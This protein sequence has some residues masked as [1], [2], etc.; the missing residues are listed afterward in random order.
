MRHYLFNVVSD[1]PAPAAGNDM[2]SW[3]L[4]YK[5]NVD[6]EVFVPVHDPTRRHFL[7]AQPGDLLWFSLDR[8]LIG[9]V[10][11]LRVMDE[12][13]QRR[14]E[15]WYDSAKKKLADER[16]VDVYT[17]GVLPEEVGETWLGGLRET[18]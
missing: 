10:P 3:F 5:W 1:L 13:S 12:P 7:E 18:L 8:K 4:F 16:R 14:V 9:A 11:I 15:V 6:D 17:T 2:G